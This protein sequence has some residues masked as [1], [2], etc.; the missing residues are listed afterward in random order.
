MGINRQTKGWK[1]DRE[2]YIDGLN[3]RQIE[4]VKQ[5]DK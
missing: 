1:T 4:M 3:K 5:M 2:E